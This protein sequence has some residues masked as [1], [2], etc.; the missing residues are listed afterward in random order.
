MRFR[1]F[2]IASTV[3]T[4]GWTALLAGAGYKLG[5]NVSEVERCI[6][7]ASNAILIVLAVGYVWRLWTHRTSGQTIMIRYGS[8]NFAI[9]KSLDL[10]SSKMV[11]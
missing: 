4:A 10:K 9:C 1:S 3:G 6:G 11:I 8:N 7:P 2:F 5:E